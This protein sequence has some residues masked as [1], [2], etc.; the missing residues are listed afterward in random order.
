MSR[1]QLLRHVKLI[2]RQITV[3]RNKRRSP[4][5]LQID[6]EPGESD[7]MP[8]EGEIDGAS[9]ASESSTRDILPSEWDQRDEK[10]IRG[11]CW[12]YICKMRKEEPSE[13]QSTTEY[14]NVWQQVSGRRKGGKAKQTQPPPLQEK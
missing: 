7:A 13:V 10:C 5:L 6:G 1:S 11:E 12:H 14:T 4:H 3:I 9:A 2:Q 8:K